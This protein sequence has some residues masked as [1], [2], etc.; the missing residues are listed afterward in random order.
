ME[1]AGSSTNKVLQLDVVNNYWAGNITST[2]DTLAT[3]TA[4][5]AEAEGASIMQITGLISATTL[6]AFTLF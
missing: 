5:P 1:V 2:F 4:L 3:P 6:A